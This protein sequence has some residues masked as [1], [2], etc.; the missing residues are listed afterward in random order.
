MNSVRQYG[1]GG[2]DDEAGPPRLS[3][4]ESSPRKFLPQK[5]ALI[6][7]LQPEHLESCARQNPFRLHWLR[8]ILKLPSDCHSEAITRYRKWN[9]KTNDQ[10]NLLPLAQF[11]QGAENAMPLSERMPQ[12]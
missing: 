9:G 8:R 7:E 10:R 4:Y 1:G 5:E 3:Q 12:S 6:R 2:G 11:V